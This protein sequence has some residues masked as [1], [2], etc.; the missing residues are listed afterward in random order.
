MHGADTSPPQ[1][2]RP[3]GRRYPRAWSRLRPQSRQSPRQACYL[4]AWSKLHENH[5]TQKPEARCSSAWTTSPHT[6]K[7]LSDIFEAPPGYRLRT[8]RTLFARLPGSPCGG[9]NLVPGEPLSGGHT[10]HRPLAP[11]MQ[12]I[13]PMY[14][15][16]LR[17]PHTRKPRFTQLPGSPCSGCNLVPGAPSQRATPDAGRWNFPTHAGRPCSPRCSR[18]ARPELPHTRGKAASVCAGRR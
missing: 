11:R 16:F 3:R 17:P 5:P 14:S 10:K 18:N 7:P 4:S 12:K 15:R 2:A 8:R 1:P 6:G 13:T 9:C